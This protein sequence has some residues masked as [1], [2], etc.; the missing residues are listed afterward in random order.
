MVIYQIKI[1]LSNFLKEFLLIEESFNL[2][3]SVFGTQGMGN[4]YLIQII[5]S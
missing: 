3:G 1:V 5:I 2:A 4:G